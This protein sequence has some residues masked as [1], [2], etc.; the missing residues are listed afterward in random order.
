MLSDELK[1]KIRDS[2]IALKDRNNQRFF[3][4]FSNR[5]ATE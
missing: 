3:A 4:G 5:D 2:F 1:A